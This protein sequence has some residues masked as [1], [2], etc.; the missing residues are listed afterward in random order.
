AGGALE[1]RHVEVAESVIRHHAVD[2]AIAAVAGGGDLAIHHGQLGGGQPGPGLPVHLLGGV[3]ELEH[4]A[5]AAP[6]GG[7]EDDAVV[8][9]GVVLDGLGGHAPAAG[10]PRG[11]AV[12]PVAAGVGPGDGLGGDAGDVGAPVVLVDGRGGACAEGLRVAGAALGGGGGVR[13]RD[14]GR[15]GAAGASLGIGGHIARRAAEAHEVEALGPV[16]VRQLEAEVDLVGAG[17]GGDDM[18]VDLAVGDGAW[19]CLD[20]VDDGVAGGDGPDG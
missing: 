20:A 18:A 19:Q 13:R 11:V 16:V 3:D 4:G 10:A 14:A 2:H 8:V 15:Q 1:A 5:A 7:A 12:Q 6:A 17:I 9:P